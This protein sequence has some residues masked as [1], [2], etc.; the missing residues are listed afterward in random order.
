MAVYDQSKVC[1]HR[2][3]AWARVRWPVIQQRTHQWSSQVNQK[4]FNYLEDLPIEVTPLSSLAFPS[5]SNVSLTTLQQKQD[6]VEMGKY[7]H[8]FMMSSLSPTSFPDS[9]YIQDKLK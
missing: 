4:A 1:F 7:F 2:L 8:D 9:A 5:L 6:E 3:E